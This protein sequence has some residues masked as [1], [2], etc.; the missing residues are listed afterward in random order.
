M[1]SNRK[2]RWRVG[3]ALALALAVPATL[4]QTQP[5]ER[6]V[7]RPDGTVVYPLV[8]ERE[9]RSGLS[10]RDRPVDAEERERRRLEAQRGAVERQEQRMREREAAL[11]NPARQIPPTVGR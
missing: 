10:S 9:T 3:G 8:N 6:T 4:A 11:E 7:T 2:W 5:Q 1:D